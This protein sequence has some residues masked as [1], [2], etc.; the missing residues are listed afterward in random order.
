MKLS[1]SNFKYQITVVHGLNPT[2]HTHRSASKSTLSA[3]TAI[4]VYG[5]TT[6]E[7]NV[8]GSRQPR[9]HGI[10][11]RRDTYIGMGALVQSRYVL[12]SVLSG[13]TPT[14]SP[15]DD[16]VTPLTP[17]AA[18]ELLPTTLRRWSRC[19]RHTWGSYLH[20]NHAE[21]PGL[22]PRRIC[23]HSEPGTKPIHSSTKQAVH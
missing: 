13:R 23:R 3:N 6:A 8:P 7:G 22:H 21:P 11:A 17:I 2:T 12:Y 19:A 18:G 20:H 14:C 16:H 10:T 4:I 9:W 15:R 1:L 5:T